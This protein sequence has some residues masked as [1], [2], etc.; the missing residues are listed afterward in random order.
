MKESTAAALALLLAGTLGCTGTPPHVGIRGIYAVDDYGA[1]HDGHTDDGPAIRAAI[2]AASTT[3]GVVSFGPGVYA[4]ADSLWIDASS[5]TLRGIG[6]GD[7]RDLD[8]GRGTVLFHRPTP[9]RSGSTAV[10]IGHRDAP[11]V[12]CNLQDLTLRGS[13]GFTGTLLS[14]AGVQ[15]C[16]L[17]RIDLYHNA[18]SAPGNA[19]LLVNCDVESA[20]TTGC[21]FEQVHVFAAKNDGGAGDAIRIECTSAGYT[22]DLNFLHVKTDNVTVPAKAVRIRHADE[23]VN[24]NHRFVSCRFDGKAGPTGVLV[25]GPRCGFLNC[26]IDNPTGTDTLLTFTRSGRDGTWSGNVDGSIADERRGMP[27][28]ATIQ[29]P[30]GISVQQ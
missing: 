4:F 14:M 18:S 19:A 12:A 5:I 21:W 27:G 28:A 26:T 13:T 9:R 16:S 15:Y 29:G 6:R 23:G 30:A 2:A 7:Q 25:D 11:T 20:P 17:E 3:G 22:T 24:A 8:S 10:L 1:A